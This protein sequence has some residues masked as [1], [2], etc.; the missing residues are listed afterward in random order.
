MIPPPAVQNLID[1]WTSAKSSKALAALLDG[2]KRWFIRLDQLSPKD[3]P[4]GHHLPSRNFSDVV[5]K[6]CSSM[7]AYG[8]LQR[9]SEEV[10]EKGSEIGP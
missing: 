8:C 6:I 10:E 1:S 5:T 7:R 2:H 3:S 4:L 9:A